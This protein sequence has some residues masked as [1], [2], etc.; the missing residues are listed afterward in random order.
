M[1][2]HD[3]IALELG[4]AIMA[5]IVAEAQRDALKAELTKLT[6]PE[7]PASEGGT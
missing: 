7:K 5:K 4:R 6:T 3:Q 1:T 2:A